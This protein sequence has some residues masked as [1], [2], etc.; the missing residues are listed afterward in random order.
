MAKEGSAPQG[1]EEAAVHISS[2]L[3]QKDDNVTDVFLESCRGLPPTYSTVDL[4]AAL[5]PGA[6]SQLEG[7]VMQRF[8]Q[9]LRPRSEN[10]IPRAITEIR[11]AAKAWDLSPLVLLAEFTDAPVSDN[12]WRLLSKLARTC[13]CWHTTRERLYT[14]RHRRRHD[15]LARRKGVSHTQPW[16]IPDIEAVL[17][18][19]GQGQQETLGDG[20]DN[21]GGQITNS[22]SPIKANISMT[23][24][25]RPRRIETID[26]DLS[27]SDM[28]SDVPPTG[29]TGEAS[30]V[31]SALYVAT[32]A[33]TKRLRLGSVHTTSRPG[34][35]VDSLSHETARSQRGNNIV[36]DANN[37]IDL[38]SRQYGTPVSESNAT[39]SN[40]TSQTGV[41]R[42]AFGWWISDDDIHRLCTSLVLLR[43][44]FE[45]VYPIVAGSD[46]TLQLRNPPADTLLVPVRAKTSSSVHWNLAVISR[47]ERLVSF[48][49]PLSRGQSLPELAA[50]M[51]PIFAR[52][53]PSE[54]LDDWAII[55][56]SCP[57]QESGS[58]SGLAVVVF[59][60]YFL[61]GRAVPLDID[62][63]IWR[64]MLAYYLAR[65]S[66][67][68]GEKAAKEVQIAS[69]FAVNH[70]ATYHEDNSPLLPP[71]SGT[72]SIINFGMTIT[73]ALAQHKP[74]MNDLWEVI[75]ASQIH[76]V[77]RRA[78]LRNSAIEG[79]AVWAA[80]LCLTDQ[81]ESCAIKERDR[82]LSALET[83]RQALETVGQQ[84]K[85]GKNDEQ[86]FRSP[87]EEALEKS[88]SLL[89]RRV[90]E[91]KLRVDGISQLRNASNAVLED[92]DELMS[93]LANCA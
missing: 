15:V 64:R 71:P 5:H 3:R 55:P 38:H 26:A 60:L 31:S 6:R 65:I 25:G 89:Q 74:G 47:A 50:I 88:V 21:E 91:A 48:Y 79:K 36:E 87:E 35:E 41:W 1:I 42:L 8:L 24:G 45:A 84:T 11:S 61:V 66:S 69:E 52:V 20:G 54:I 34:K 90:R 67:V 62:L 86:I 85:T 9:R 92:L 73:E 56:R 23:R 37:P 30:Q 12:F 80:V 16:A 43:P 14:E 22:A 29:G 81:V 70:I 68:D 57:L 46:T 2:L 7:V 72:Q 83:T 63:W 33:T 76:L 78:A 53:L 93:W 4:V 10:A 40:K 75:K 32:S 44:T 19:E 39:L 18:I 77:E 13:R 28:D 82:N 27:R 49:N 58:D 51:Q 17:Q 59:G